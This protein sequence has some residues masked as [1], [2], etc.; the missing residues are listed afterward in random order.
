MPGKEEKTRRGKKEK[1]RRK[2]GKNRGS[3]RKKV[4]VHLFPMRSGH[5]LDQ[6]EIRYLK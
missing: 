6:P 2:A 3:N 1:K 4:R 5:F